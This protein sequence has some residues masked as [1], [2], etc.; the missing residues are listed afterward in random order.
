MNT[1][2]LFYYQK[3]QCCE[4]R[5]KINLGSN[6]AQSLEHVQN[7]LSSAINKHQK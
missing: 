6:L 4:C 5:Y 3:I 7:V 2:V 1:A